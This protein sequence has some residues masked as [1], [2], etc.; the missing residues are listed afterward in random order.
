MLQSRFARVWLLWTGLYVALA[1][2]GPNGLVRAPLWPDVSQ[3]LLQAR[4]WLGADIRIPIG[5]T[6]GVEVLSVAPRLDVTPYF[7]NRPVRDPRE[8]ALVSNL[9]VGVVDAGGG[10]VPVQSLW[11]L[12][13]QIPESD[14]LVCHVGFPPGPAFFL[15]PFVALLGGAVATQWLA[16][17]LGGLGVAAFD[18][19]AFEWIDVVLDQRP[20]MLRNPLMLL[21]GGGTLFMWVVPDGG[22]FLFA[23]TVACALSAASLLAAW[24]GR[25][26]T[27]GLLFGLALTSRPAMVGGL[28]LLA[29]I[30]CVRHCRGGFRERLWAF[31]RLSFGPVACGGCALALNYLRFGSVWDFGYRFM[32]VPPFLRERL[33]EHGQLSWHYLAR[34]LHAVLWNPPVVV[35][36]ESGTSVFPFFASDPVGM[37]VLWVTPAFLALALAV[38]AKGRTGRVLLGTCWASL[39]LS[40]LPGLLYYNTGW[41]QWGG[42]FLLDAWPMWLLLASVGLSRIPRV[43]VWC[44]VAASVLSCSWAVVATTT[45]A[46]PG[47]CS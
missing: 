37:G 43:V 47:C 15:L 30:A 39:V 8:N 18:A 23:Q 33:L 6:G 38:S 25:L 44:L 42:R 29:S 20:D 17:L 2:S 26:W 24:R 41:V 28:V 13:G 7:K 4:A 11:G 16:A 32:I 1:A 5:E 9:A 45:G 35:R 21:A 14:E 12:Y 3:H 31:C 36:T 46:W 22:T 27:A 34:N 19:L 40:C 10:L